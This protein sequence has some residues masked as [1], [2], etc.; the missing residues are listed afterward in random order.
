MSDS[1]QPHRWQPTR[2]PR[3]W[4]SPDNTGV[5]C[6][7]LLQCMKVVAQSCPTL[8]N[9]VDC[10]PPDFS[11]PG[12]LQARILEW[13]SIPFSR[14]SSWLRDQPGLQHCRRILYCLSQ[15]LSNHPLYMVLYTRPLVNE[16][17]IFVR[18]IKWRKL[19]HRVVS[20]PAAGMLHDLES[21]I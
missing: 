5:G 13:V 17:E 16:Q 3:P 8:S 2:L 18:L 19:K 9:P 6:H 7:F 1:V 21:V 4:D 14:G 11:V 10:S 15:G 20:H 12:I